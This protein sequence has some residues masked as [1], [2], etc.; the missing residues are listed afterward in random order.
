M[1]EVVADYYELAVPRNATPGQY[2]VEVRV[3]TN[4]GGIFSDLPVMQEGVSRDYVA[5]PP[6]TVQ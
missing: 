6:I 1:G 4:V 2:H 3:Y 5:L